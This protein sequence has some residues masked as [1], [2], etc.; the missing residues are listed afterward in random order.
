MENWMER[1]EKRKDEQHEQEL[2]E[3]LERMIEYLENRTN[4][5][6]TEKINILKKITETYHN[7]ELEICQYDVEDYNRKKKELQIL[8]DKIKSM[9]HKDSR[10]SESWN[11]YQEEELRNEEV[12]YEDDER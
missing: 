7:L 9:E 2:R 10:E 6:T 5:G 8:I 3:R 4:I 1:Y 12:E 11:E